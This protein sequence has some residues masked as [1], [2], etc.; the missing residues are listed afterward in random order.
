MFYIEVTSQIRRCQY[1]A[2]QF[3]QAG[4]VFIKYLLVQYIF[5]VAAFFL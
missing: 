2:F 1:L 3:V 5:K 4:N